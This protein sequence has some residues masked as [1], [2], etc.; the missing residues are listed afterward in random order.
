MK[1]KEKLNKKQPKEISTVT[2]KKKKTQKDIIAN[3]QILL[4]RSCSDICFE[5]LVKHMKVYCV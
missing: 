4:K 2:L 1:K 3:V 5:F